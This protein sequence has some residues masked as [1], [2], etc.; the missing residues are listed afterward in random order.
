MDSAVMLAKVFGPCLA[1]IGIWMLLYTDNLLKILT[2]M[3]N[4]PAAFYNSAVLNLVV[5][6]FI[7]TS[8]NGWRMDVF[9]FVTLLG[10]VFFIRGLLGFFLPQVIIKLYFD[11]NSW[12]KVM[13]IVPLLWGIILIWAGFYR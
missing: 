1:I 4:S 13:G 7:V 9:V 12:T 11:K 6:L 8:Y 2:S 10:W 5:G 3:K